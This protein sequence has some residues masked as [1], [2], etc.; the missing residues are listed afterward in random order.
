[1]ARGVKKAF[2]EEGVARLSAPRGGRREIGDAVQRGLVLRI[3]ETGV[4][5]W[6]VIYKV[7][8]ERGVSPTGRPL[9]G[10]QKRITIGQYPAIGVAAARE[11]AGRIIRQALE[12][13]DPRPE[14]REAN[15]LR[16]TNSVEAVSKRMV[17]LAKKQVETWPGWSRCCAITSGPPWATV[18]SQT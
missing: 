10:S 9:K 18:R 14:R 13:K 16:H 12:G 8:G 7:P 2:T 4:K 3:G 17:E 11:E 15:L 6:S 1:M 5:S